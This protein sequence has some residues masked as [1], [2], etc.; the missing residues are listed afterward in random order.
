MISPWAVIQR[1]VSTSQQVYALNGVPW[2][3]VDG[4]ALRRSLFVSY[5][6]LS[7]FMLIVIN[8][9]FTFGKSSYI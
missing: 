4:G 8:Y 1:A 7:F 3:I 6:I 2:F 5:D 9:N